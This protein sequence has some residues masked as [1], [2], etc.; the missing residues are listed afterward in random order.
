MSLIILSNF[1]ILN[2]PPSGKRHR[3]FGHKYI[4]VSREIFHPGMAKRGFYEKPVIFHS[5][6]WRHISANMNLR[7]HSCDKLKSHQ[8]LSI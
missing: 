4:E 8:R 5:K 1:K 2:S 7:G 3:V 6:T